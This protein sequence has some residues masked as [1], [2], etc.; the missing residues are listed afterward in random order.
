MPVRDVYLAV[1]PHRRGLAHALPY[2]QVLAI[3]PSEVAY[4][5][6][7]EADK[8][9]RAVDKLVAKNLV[10]RKGDRKDRRRVVLTL[11]P[12]GRRVYEEIESVRRAIERR[13]LSVLSAKEMN[14]FFDAMDKLQDNARRIFVGRDAWK[15]IVAD[16]VG[17]RTKV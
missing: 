7:L 16:D 12:K 2:W 15:A 8:V 6:S 3:Y 11:T 5:S 9:T 17:G 10:V 13:F 14:I 1:S 4:H